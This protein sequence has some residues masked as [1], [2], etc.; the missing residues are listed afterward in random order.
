MVLETERLVQVLLK[1]REKKPVV[2]AITNWI[3]ANEVASCLHAVG[4]R[5]IMAT[6]LEEIEEITSKAD[7]LVLNL[8]TPSPERIEAMLLS[9]RQANRDNHP[10]VF[11][12]VGVSGSRFRI[13][14][15]RRI[16][17]ELRITAIRGNQSEIGTLAGQKSHLAGV[18]SV[19][20]PDD[21]EQ[22]CRYLSQKTGAVVVASGPEDLI[23]SSEKKAV[24]ENGHPL[25]P[26][27]TGMGCMLNAILGAFNAVESD[28]MTATVSAVAF[29][30]LTGELA[31]LLAKGPGT[32]KAAFFDALYSLTPERMQKG[33]KIRF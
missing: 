3:T 24:V 13:E 4:A 26:Q 9:G 17:S 21:L 16:L 12:P 33:M 7:A 6:A 19:S 32:F 14:S 31:G 27:V 22:A 25:M 23:I 2:H 28:P 1:V 8:G 30:G 11:D 5:P 18:D 29:F 15:S 20:G 10:I